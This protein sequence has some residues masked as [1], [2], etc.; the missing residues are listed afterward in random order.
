MRE[1]ETPGVTQP[2]SCQPGRHGVGHTEGKKGK[3]QHID[4]ENQIKSGDKN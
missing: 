2:G 1:K 3:R 4:K